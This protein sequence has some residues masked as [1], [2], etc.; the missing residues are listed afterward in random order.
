MNDHNISVGSAK[1][2]FVSYWGHEKIHMYI[3]QY[4]GM[5]GDSKGVLTAHIVHL[6]FAG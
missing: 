5:K 6:N 2:V 3:V 1:D 4:V